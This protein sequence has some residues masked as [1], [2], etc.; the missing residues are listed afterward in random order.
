MQFKKAYKGFYKSR[1]D[2]PKAPI[3]KE[4]EL[5][6]LISYNEAKKFHCFLGRLND[7][8]I[9]VD[10][11]NKLINGE[12]DINKSQS[13]RLIEILKANG[14]DTPI[15]ET[16][17]GHHFI[18][19]LTNDTLKN[20]TGVQTPI[21]LMVDYKKGSSKGWECLKANG[22]ERT[23]IN[24]TDNI[25]LLPN[26]LIH[27]PILKNT[28]EELKDGTADNGRNSFLSKYKYLLFKAGYE[29]QEVFFIINTINKYILYEP[30][31]GKELNTIMR[32][33][34]IEPNEVMKKENDFYTVN[35]NGKRKFISEKLAK[36]LVKKYKTIKLDI[37]ELYFYNGKYYEKPISV[38]QIHE[39]IYK[40]CEELDQKQ[41][42]EV[43][44]KML[45]E[46]PNKVRNF[47]YINF[48]NGLLSVEE[49]RQGNFKMIDHSD[50]IITTNI[51]PW[52]FKT[53]VNTEN[54]ERYLKSLLPPN[55]NDLYYLLIEFLGYCFL[56]F[57]E[58][59]KNLII[60]GNNKNGKSKFLE[61]ARNGFGV[62]NVAQL[63]IK[64]FT[65]RFSLGGIVGKTVNLGD[66]NS[67][68]FIE[69]TATL[70]KVSTGEPYYIEFKGKQAFLYNGQCKLIFTFN[71]IAGIN[72]PT[73]AIKRR[74]IIIP[75]SNDFT[76]NGDKHIVKKM[77][78][79]ENSHA[80]IYLALTGLI[81]L[82]K[83]GD[84]THSKTAD[85]LLDEFNA[86]NDHV[87]LFVDDFTNNWLNKQAFNKKSVDE[88]YTNYYQW[89]GIN[90]HN[91]PLAKNKLTPR[92]K[93]YIDLEV[94]FIKNKG[95]STRIY[96]NKESQ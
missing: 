13:K 95:K 34:H 22:V 27:N 1:E 83:N 17:H 33:E 50:K 89:C 55:D 68:K 74:F 12:Y 20:Y 67:D 23:I 18:F 39:L 4:T 2:N 54:V 21:G 86:N 8:F 82:L 31:T 24:D 72:D 85:V 30:L 3:L 47:D 38:E 19:K 46:S 48:N 52:D 57:N 5:N 43:Y 64:H 59:S 79:I 91:R 87:A 49:L 84:F 81:R 63:D 62:T 40:E 45:Y 29:E 78:T 51:T 10:I 65:E 26:W 28:L 36:Y 60:K 80:F 76:K 53:D 71:E 11:D 90:G 35:E 58:F 7:D 73:G 32:Q 92:I 25:A 41:R 56:P 96:I 94:I 70:K 15:I 44:K 37:V 77:T 6:K 42:N 69:E 93:K 75:F 14:I 9:L 66:D 88:V 61:V 16:N